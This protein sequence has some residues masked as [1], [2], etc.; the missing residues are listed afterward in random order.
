M[1]RKKTKGMTKRLMSLGLAS[2]LVFSSLGLS[3]CGNKMTAIVMRLMKSEGQ[4]V[5]TDE[6]DAEKSIMED[7]NLYSGYHLKTGSASEAQVSLDDTRLAT[8]S[9]NS[10]LGFEKEK[11]A[12]KLI[13]E[14]GELFFNVTEKLEDDESCEVET[15]TMIVGIRGTSLYVNGDTV[16]LTNGKITIE[17]KDPESKIKKTVTLEGGQQLTI[18]PSTEE[19]GK[20][21]YVVEDASVENLPDF[22]KEAILNDSTLAEKVAETFEI[23]KAELIEEL[24]ES[25]SDGEDESDEDDDEDDD[26]DEDDED[27][28]EETTQTQTTRRRQ[29]NN[30]DNETDP[31]EMTPEQLAAAQAQL[32]KEIAEKQAAEAAAAAAAA[33][34]TEETQEPA[35]PVATTVSLE[36][37]EI[38]QV[39]YDE[40]GDTQ[41]S[42]TLRDQ[43]RVLS[44]S[45][46][47]TSLS[48]NGI[49]ITTSE[50]AAEAPN[51][52]A[53][54]LSMSATVYINSGETAPA[55]V[56]YNGTQV[57]FRDVG[58]GHRA[59]LDNASI[60]FDGQTY[61][62]E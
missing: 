5:L 8:L 3:A 53:S 17:I 56:L 16:I 26:E 14:K 19:S 42:Y 50:D 60:F 55:S 6:K 47:G 37:S 15:S 22:A 2:V 13:L 39:V 29:T 10:L 28:E 20:N 12:L 57:A 35:G 27:G 43:S 1:K 38:L 49:S 18:V 59:E 40:N 62:F 24:K 58:E 23:T 32:A 9:E 52:Y 25:L 11:K 44:L 51:R 41:S 54:V 4:V 30:N 7:M 45:G 61:R 33:A 46:S 48:Y 21:T 34:A 36:F 31:N